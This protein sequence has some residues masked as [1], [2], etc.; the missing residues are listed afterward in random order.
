MVYIWPWFLSEYWRETCS[1]CTFNVGALSRI[2]RI[3]SKIFAE[4]VVDLVYEEGVI[5]G[6]NESFFLPTRSIRVSARS[7]AQT[8]LTLVNRSFYAWARPPSDRCL[9]NNARFDS[10]HNDLNVRS[11]FLGT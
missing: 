3:S 2:E 4:V 5:A 9:S 11:D 1:I 10:S 6:I 7:P 8:S